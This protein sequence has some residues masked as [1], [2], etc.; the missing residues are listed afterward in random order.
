MTPDEQARLDA[1]AQRHARAQVGHIRR[2]HVARIATVSKATA[3][4]WGH[5]EPDVGFLLQI[6]RKQQAQIRD[7]V[8]QG[9][10]F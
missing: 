9:V 6:I 3:E 10:P 7:C 2:Q 4:F 5:S 8:C 1:I